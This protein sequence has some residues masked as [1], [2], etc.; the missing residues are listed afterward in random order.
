MSLREA[1]FIA[2]L[3]VLTIRWQQTKYCGEARNGQY[4]P[5][6]KHSDA[7]GQL[8]GGDGGGVFSSLVF[9]PL[10]LS[11]LIY[12]LSSQFPD[13]FRARNTEWSPRTH[14]SRLLHPHWQPTQGIT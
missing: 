8:G 7:L 13:H 1:T 3:A 6:R 2:C 11:S 5:P 9:F 14:T 12:R 10:G 4:Q